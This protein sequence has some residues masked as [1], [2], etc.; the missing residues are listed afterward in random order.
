MSIYW[1]W[2]KC[3]GRLLR[4]VLILFCCP[5]FLWKTIY[6]SYLWC[7]TNFPQTWRHKQAPVCRLTV[8]WVGSPSSVQWVLSSGCHWLKPRAGWSRFS[9]QTAF[10]A[11]LLSLCC[12][13][14]VALSPWRLPLVFCFKASSLTAWLVAAS[15]PTEECPS[16][17][18][19]DRVFWDITH[20]IPSPP[21]SQGRA[22]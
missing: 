11:E 9:H 4:N 12:R 22:V 8:V 15:E 7:I 14:D 10:Q 6:I 16:L 17:V 2:L 1:V 19:W 3:L 5:S 20:H 13:T 21:T 18:C